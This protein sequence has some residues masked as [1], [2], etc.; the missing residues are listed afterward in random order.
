MSMS[1]ELVPVP[2]APVVSSGRQEAVSAGAPHF[3]NG[4][5]VE[6]L[7]YG[8]LSGSGSASAA[9]RLYFAHQTG[10]RLKQVRITLAGGA[11]TVESGALHY[12]K[13]KIEVTNKAGG[14]TG[15]L[16]KLVTAKL[17]GESAFNPTYR[18][19]GELVLE[20][21]FGHFL[22]LRLENEELVVDKG[23]FYAAE[24]TV[25]VGVAM[26]K[27]LSSALFGG[28]GLFQTSLR[29][30]GLV[31]LASPVA[32]EE[33]VK[34]RLDGDT[35]QVD[36]N[37]ALLR[38]GN[39]QFSVEKSTKSLFGTLTSGEG[40]LQTFRGTGE[41]WIAPTQVVYDRLETEGLAAV[42]Q[43]QASSDNQSA[44]KQSNVFGS[45]LKFLD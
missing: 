27:N 34:Y 5:S 19:K 39:V 11:V 6:V 17:T 45:L 25:T 41:V 8:A 13:G 14:V 36:G 29:G 7:T 35:L 37:F 26:Q 15:A 44:Q 24:S 23:M 10:M 40:L 21:S 1:S 28:E 32:P 4:L 33:L 31:V 43:A 16:T 3:G 22:V 12:L 20:P 2:V 18:G 42:T 30:S 38:K 9:Q